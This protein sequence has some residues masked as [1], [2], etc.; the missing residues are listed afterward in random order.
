MGAAIAAWQPKMAAASQSQL[1]AMAADGCMAAM[2][3]SDLA[4]EM[5]A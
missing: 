3:L 5:Q 2:Q 1:A 4:A